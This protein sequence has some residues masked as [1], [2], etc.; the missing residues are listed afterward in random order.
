MDEQA[1]FPNDVFVF[2]VGTTLHWTQRGLHKFI[3]NY[4]QDTLCIPERIYINCAKGHVY[5]D[6]E[7]GFWTSN[8][9][10]YDVMLTRAEVIE[11]LI[12]S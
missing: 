6:R 9:H 3:A 2:P 7:C 1:I 12:N 10:E 8:F 11:I 5:T 4:F